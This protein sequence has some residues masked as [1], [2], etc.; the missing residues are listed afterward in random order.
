MDLNLVLLALLVLS[1]IAAVLVPSLLHSAI[2][3][4]VASV[5]LTILMFQLQAPLAGVF[6]LS[7]CAGL[8]T[9]IFVSAISL[10]RPGSGDEREANPALKVIL[11]PVIVAAVGGIFL[12]ADLHRLP[13]PPV[14][15]QADVR[16][17]LWGLRQFDLLGIV[18]MILVGVF[19][20][21][22]L[23]KER[24]KHD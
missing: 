21:V 4:A 16:Q 1:G 14:A 11:L 19:G 5:V 23:F 7:V 3:L 6:E 17:V 10:T 13:V 12:L 15:P 18:V 24:F 2:S 22:I 20:V 8:I 9:A